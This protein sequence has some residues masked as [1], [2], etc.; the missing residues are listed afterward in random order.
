MVVTA[1]S[2]PVTP[3]AIGPP[4]VELVKTFTGTATLVESINDSVPSGV[5]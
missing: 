3:P 5:S 4:V 1:F 2:L